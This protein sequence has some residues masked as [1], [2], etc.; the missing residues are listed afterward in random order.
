[1]ADGLELRAPS[2]A[3]REDGSV[4]L[5]APPTGAAPL[6]LEKTR[7]L[8]AERRDKAW[9]DRVHPPP[10]IN[11]V[12]ERTLDGQQPVR[13]DAALWRHSQED[14]VGYLPS[15]SIHHD[16]VKSLAWYNEREPYDWARSFLWAVDA[17]VRSEP[18]VT[19]IVLD[20]PPGTWGLPHETMVIVS[21][22]LR[23]A[24][25]PDGYPPWHEGP[26]RW[27]ANPFL[28]T[29]SDGNDLLP[30]LEY[31]GR[32]RERLRTLQPIA[33]RLTEGE[34]RMRERARALLGPVLAP[35][36]LEKLIRSV[37]D[38]AELSRIFKEGDIPLNESV[39]A[40]KRTLRIGEET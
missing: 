38:L 32:H 7:S 27:R 34:D 3:T 13:V 28:V 20:L 30:A 6:G 4:D 2:V 15:S 10:Y 31:I 35:I 21:T 8:R 18:N 26:V 16:I 12:L 11:D 39:R 29:S 22:L 14:G 25:L 17:L 23:K 9:K 24:P 37:P 36:G 1:I 19:D 40:I 5:A 33:N